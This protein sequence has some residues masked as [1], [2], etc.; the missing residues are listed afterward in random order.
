MCDVDIA[1]LLKSQ[2]FQ[3]TIP[4]L[5]A[6]ET[7]VLF[8]FLCAIGVVSS[9]NFPASKSSAFI[10]K[11]SHEDPDPNLDFESFGFGLNGVDTDFMWIDTV[12]VDP[13]SYTAEFSND[14]NICLQ[15]L[16]ALQLHPSSTVLNYGQALFEG[17]KAFRRRD[18]SIIIFRPHENAKRL[19]NGARR[20]LLPEIPTA[21]FLG[22]VDNVVRSN[23]KF[24]PPAGKGA[25]YM[26]P[27]LFGSEKSLGVK[28]AHEATFC[29]YA[30]PVGNYFKGALKC[31]KLQAVRGYSRAGRGGSGCVKASGNYAPPFLVQKQVRERGFDEAL[32]LDCVRLV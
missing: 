24:I 7:I 3:K 11:G 25:L 5:C 10:R 22:A 23:S 28:P 18:G 29:V 27:L 20:L 2:V 1:D 12:E 31:I 14:P 6:M 9:T 16:A 8:F 13:A 17:L 4:Y 15:K 32:F 26:R 30:S 19:A 21:T